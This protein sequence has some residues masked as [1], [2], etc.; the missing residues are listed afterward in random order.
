MIFAVYFNVKAE[1]NKYVSGEINTAKN[2]INNFSNIVVN[3]KS[4]VFLYLSD[5]NAIYGSVNLENYKVL[6]DTLFI[7][8]TTIIKIDFSNIQSI[9]SNYGSN[10]IIDSIYTNNLN[11]S[12]TNNSEIKI[13]KGTIKNLSV[14]SDS[15]NIYLGR[16]KLNN[17]NGA[18][19][20]NSFI[21]FYSRLKSINIDTDTSS[22]FNA[23]GWRR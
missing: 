22:Y 17:L 21:S 23:N 1:V 6:N 14:S 8:D 10:I 19:T 18:L 20:N 15:S 12:A 3:T 2:T 11:I 5:D 13:K 16:C 4:T 9:T 7:S